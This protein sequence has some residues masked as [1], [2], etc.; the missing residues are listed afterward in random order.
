VNALFGMFLGAALVV[1]AE[2]IALL[3]GVIVTG[4]H[5]P[6]YDIDEATRQ[7]HARRAVGDSLTVMTPAEPDGRTL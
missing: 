2:G 5:Q 7:Y 1:I 3:V 4:L 6:R